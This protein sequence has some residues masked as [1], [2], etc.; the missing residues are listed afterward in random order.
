[1]MVQSKRISQHM[2]ATEL[3]QGRSDR[4]Y[5]KSFIEFLHLAPESTEDDPSTTLV[6]HSLGEILLLAV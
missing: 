2:A 4:S 1:M 5:L 3:C 6:V